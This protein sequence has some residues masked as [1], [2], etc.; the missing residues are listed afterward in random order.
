MDLLEF[1]KW[2]ERA[3]EYAITI[4]KILDIPINEKRR[5]LCLDRNCY[6]IAAAFPN[7][8][9]TPYSPDEFFK[10]NY[11][12]DFTRRD[13]LIGDWSWISLSS[14]IVYREEIREFE[15]DLGEFWF[16]LE[17][18]KVPERDEQGIFDL[19]KHKNKHWRDLDEN[20]LIGWRGVMV[21]WDDLEKLPYIYYT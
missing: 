14:D 10:R 16:P 3:D 1:D 8:P 20:T 6:D 7:I 15:I 12:F 9:H 11:V 18:N 19:S 21:F 17:N 5:I 13:G 2:L 4:K